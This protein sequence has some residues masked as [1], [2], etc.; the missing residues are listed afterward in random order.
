[1]LFAFAFCRQRPKTVASTAGRVGERGEGSGGK[2]GVTLLLCAC[3]RHIWKISLS[4]VRE[5][6]S[7]R[8][9]AVNA[10]SKI[11]CAMLK[12]GAHQEGG[13]QKGGWQRP[14]LPHTHTHTCKNSCQMGAWGMEKFVPSA[15]GNSCIC[16][17]KGRGRA[18]QG[19]QVEG[20]GGGVRVGAAFWGWLCAFGA[21]GKRWNV[22]QIE[23]YW[24]VFEIFRQSLQKEAHTHTGVGQR[25]YRGGGHKGD[26]GCSC[27]CWGYL[28]LVL[29]HCC[30]ANRAGRQAGRH[31]QVSP[32]HGN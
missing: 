19:R 13:R 16:E 4:R 27:V 18:G 20:R 29:G 22:L 10:K 1:M 31:R 11:F 14:L 8:S 17:Q 7:G 23:F 28:L 24:N 15:K 32:V 12:A 25:G 30:N 9:G 6:T 26:T 2:V 5:G 21:S 3:V